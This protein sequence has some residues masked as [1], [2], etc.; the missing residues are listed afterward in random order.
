MKKVLFPLLITISSTFGWGQTILYSEDFDDVNDMDGYALRDG[1]HND[2]SFS[3]PN[4]SYIRRDEP[5]DLPIGAT[6]TTF[7]GKAIGVENT[8]ET[9]ST[10]L[11]YVLTN[12]FSIA[13]ESDLSISLRLAVPRNSS[14][15]IYETFDYVLVEYS[16]DAGAW[17]Q[18]M[19]FGGF[20]G[21]FLNKKVYFDGDNNGLT[22]TFDDVLCT[23][24]G[25]VYS[26]DIPATGNNMAVR[27]TFASWGNNEEFI[28]D[29]V[30]VQSVPPCSDVEV[31]NTLSDCD[32]V[33]FSGNYYYSDETIR[34]TIVDAVAPGCD[35]IYITDLVV[36][37]PNFNELT[38]SPFPA[39]DD[40]VC[41]SVNFMN[42]PIANPSG[43]SFSGPG[44]ESNSH[45]NPSL[46]TPGTYYY[47]YSTTDVNGCL[48]H[49]STALTVE[50]C[51]G[52]PD[53]N[54]T[55]QISV[56]PNPIEDH[57]VIVGAENAILII[58]N[59]QGKVLQRSLIKSNKEFVYLESRINGMLILS[60]EKEGS[61]ERFLVV[62]N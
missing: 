21:G 2:I 48:I 40:T 55:S 36:H 9:F 19:Y 24:D 27:I 12:A 8:D 50:N 33:L 46:I 14:G 51:V 43:G 56:Y 20:D 29:D 42:F 57:F 13:G 11:P 38:L 6:M 44:I 52:I 39:E 47:T 32:S 22:A 10:G 60:I 54:T 3:G 49:D 45:I 41:S 30:I 23:D 31:S 28:I 25:T 59:M 35:S 62:K 61:A 5:A 15:T 37:T 7:T 4:D 18:I 16:I 17:Q 26:Q 53:Q 1:A 34:D 58:T